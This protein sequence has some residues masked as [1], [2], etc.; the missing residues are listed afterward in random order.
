MPNYRVI[1]EPNRTAHPSCTS[2]HRRL[3]GDGRIKRI[4]THFV[5]SDIL[6]ATQEAVASP[7]HTG[8]NIISIEERVPAEALNFSDHEISGAL[9]LQAD[10]IEKLSRE[11][12]PV[13]EPLYEEAGF[14]DTV[15]SVVELLS[16]SLIPGLNI[17]VVSNLDG[18]HYAMVEVRDE[19]TGTYVATTADMRDLIED[20]SATGWKGVVSIARALI[21]TAEPLV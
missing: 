7:E 21:N 13:T 10:G 18:D 17:S 8:N 3:R 4:V 12:F 20:R 6:K 2:A 16:D 9:L 15:V 14:N 19:A 5:A 11:D 1:S